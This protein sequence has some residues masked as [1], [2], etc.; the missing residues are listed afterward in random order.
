MRIKFEKGFTPERIADAFVEYVR[1]NNLLIGSVNIYLQTY[2]DEM[3]TEKFTSDY[4]EFS[5]CDRT[6]KEYE[7]EVVEYRR[8]K[9]K[10]V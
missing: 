7:N 4:T 3:K 8:G 2:D 6:K 9:M 5:P 10:A 1:E